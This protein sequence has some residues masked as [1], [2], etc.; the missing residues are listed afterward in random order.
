MSY[1]NGLRLKAGEN[2]E[3]E[4]DETGYA[5]FLEQNLR[6]NKNAKHLDIP[7]QVHFIS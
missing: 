2:V 4:D 1:Y 7:S 6:T 5:I 3:G